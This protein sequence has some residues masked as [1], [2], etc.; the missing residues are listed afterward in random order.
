MDPK[1]SR[2]WDL[3]APVPGHWCERHIILANRDRFYDYYAESLCKPPTKATRLLIKRV[4]DNYIMYCDINAESARI[5]EFLYNL[6]TDVDPAELFNINTLNLIFTK[7]T[8]Q[9]KPIPADLVWKIVAILDLLDEL[10]EIKVKRGLLES[11]ITLSTSYIYNYA[12][13]R[14]SSS[15]EIMEQTDIMYVYILDWVF[16]RLNS[17]EYWLPAT[18]QSQIK[19]IITKLG[20]DDSDFYIPDRTLCKIQ[21]SLALFDMDNPASQRESLAQIRQRILP[22]KTRA[23]IHDVLSHTNVKQEPAIIIDGANWFYDAGLLSNEL[24]H[25]GSATWQKSILYH[26]GLNNESLGNRA[27]YIVFNG[28]HR[29]QIMNFALDWHSRLRT[30]YGNRIQFIYTRRGVNDDAMSLYLWLT[31]PGS[32]LFSNDNYGDWYNRLDNNLYYQGLWCCWM[33]KYKVIR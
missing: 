13:T 4:F 10:L 28:R 30:Q 5:L 23:W 24:Y 12:N 26:A 31:Y 11:L 33:T 27:I 14:E 3:P 22:P 25:V 16:T 21:E 1:Y 29:V 18:T 2:H 7:L 32:I 9:P 19:V 15:L 17:R 20:C 8:E 6:L